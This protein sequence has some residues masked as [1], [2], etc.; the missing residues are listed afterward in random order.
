M[1]AQDRIRIIL[2][3]GLLGAFV[4]LFM[5]W[6]KYYTHTIGYT[7]LGLASAAVGLMIAGIFIYMLRKREKES[8]Y[9]GAYFFIGILIIAFVVPL[10]FLSNH[11]IGYGKVEEQTFTI[12][13]M[14]AVHS[15]PYG[16]LSKEVMDVDYYRIWLEIKGKE[17]K[18]N[19]GAKYKN[20]IIDQEITLPIRRGLWGF[21]Q[22]MLNK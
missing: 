7:T 15:A 6:L 17:H 3:L 20:R 4:A 10:A 9:L 16:I 19:L 13:R 5:W 11:Y 14:N 21:D 8:M 12:N 22:V 1:N 2:G 18:M